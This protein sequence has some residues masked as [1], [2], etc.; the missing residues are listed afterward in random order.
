MDPV[1]KFS[2][3]HT[4]GHQA[5]GDVSLRRRL[6]RV[7]VVDDNPNTMIL[8]HDLLSSRGYDVVA[9]PDAA[10]AEAEILRRVPD[11]VLSDVIMPG[12]SG[13]E[14]CRELKENPATRLVPVV[15]ITGLSEREDRVRGIEAGA[16]DFLSKPIFPEELIARVKSLLKLKEFTDELETAE[17]VICTLALSVESRDPYTEGHCE[18]LALNAS[19]MGRHL[20]LDQDSIVALR[21]GGYLHDLGKIA[22]PDEILKKGSN[23]PPSEWEIMKK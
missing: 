8:M 9:V 6:P 17:S 7:L 10:Q 4:R 15:L 2:T 11:L 14:L 3:I 12:K 19:E 20:K 1:R 21:R 13:Y 23:L 18:R 5:A 22:V 16:D